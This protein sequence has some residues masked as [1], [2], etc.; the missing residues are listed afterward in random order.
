[1]RT[2]LTEEKKKT[3][4]ELFLWQ[5]NICWD[6]KGIGATLSCML[7]YFSSCKIVRSAYDSGPNHFTFRAKLIAFLV[8]G[9]ALDKLA[10]L[11][12]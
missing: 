2:R 5:N 6:S 10:I 3:D 12:S 9:M 7:E 4:F 8:L 1:M 11:W